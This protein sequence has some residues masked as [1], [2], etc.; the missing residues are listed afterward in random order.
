MIKEIEIKV[1]TDWAGISLQ[2]WLELQKDIKSYEGEDDAIN[3]LIFHHLCGLDVENV[4]RLSIEDYKT[5]KEE[6][7]KFMMNVELPLQQLITIDGVEY[8]F[9]PNLSE[10]TYGAYADITKYD[11]IG[12]DDNW[13]K[14]MAILYRPVKNKSKSMYSIE[15]YTGE[16]DETKFLNVG[17]DVHFGTLFFFLNLSMDLL[18]GILKSS[19]EGKVPHN[20]QSILARSGEVIQHSL[21]LQKGTFLKLIR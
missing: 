3:A 16:V 2:K 21:N 15:S 14:I 1:P 13:A 4:N 20:I 19:T 11:N 9:E 6:L 7:E 5:I 10:M 17:M 12:I 8:G 18:N